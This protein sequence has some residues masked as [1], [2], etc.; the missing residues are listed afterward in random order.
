MHGSQGRCYMARE[1]KTTMFEDMKR[2]MGEVD[3]ET[4]PEQGT[5]KVQEGYIQGTTNTGPTPV[6]NVRIDDALW[7]AAQKY[8]KARGLSAGAVVRLALADL[9]RGR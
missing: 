8:G 4:T 6:R 7:G 5:D 9:L 1:K 3:P 2:A